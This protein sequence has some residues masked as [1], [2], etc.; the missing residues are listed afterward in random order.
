[1]IGRQDRCADWQR[2]C[3][4]RCAS[5]IRFRP[6]GVF[7]PVESPPCRRHFFLP[8]TIGALQA[9]P[10]D[11]ANAPHCAIGV[12]FCTLLCNLSCLTLLGG[13]SRPARG[14]RAV[15]VDAAA[16]MLKAQAAALL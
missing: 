10:V 8:G 6:S 4:R 13:G 9:S 3:R 2:R 1:M 15:Q 11:L 7:G 14:A 5:E 16:R 12:P